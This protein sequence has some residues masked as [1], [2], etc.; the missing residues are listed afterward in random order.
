MRVLRLNFVDGF[1]ELGAKK[2]IAIP[3]AN[4]TTSL[5][6][7][8]IEKVEDGFLCEW[9]KKV[10]FVPFTAVTTAE[11]DPRSLVNEEPLPGAS[12]A[13][14][15]AADNEDVGS[16]VASLS[17][18]DSRLFRSLVGQYGV[19]QAK[20][21]MGLVK[22]APVPTAASVQRYVTQPDGL[23]LDV[24]TGQYSRLAKALGTAPHND[25]MLD[26]QGDAE[27]VATV[28]A[29]SDPMDAPLEEPTETIV[30]GGHRPRRRRSK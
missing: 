23:V 9:K 4:D 26:L 19:R 22:A 25:G 14:A 3:S 10:F 2:S 7:K 8:K 11:I 18:A 12:D 29:S 5:Q 27:P 6:S 21:K 17:E 1:T 30:I 15:D 20:V 16:T 24:L 28:P 13:A